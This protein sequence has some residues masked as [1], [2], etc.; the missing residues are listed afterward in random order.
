MCIQL[1]HVVSK[2]S[3]ALLSC[4]LPPEGSTWSDPQ[5][6]YNNLLVKMYN[7]VNF[8][9]VYVCGDFNS[10]IGSLADWICDSDLG[11]TQRVCLDDTI[12]TQGEMLIEFLRDSKCCVLNGRTPG[13]N[14]FTSISVKGK[15]G[16]GLYH[17]NT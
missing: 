3:L 17:Y 13:I 8:A 7:L 9:V 14:N 12:N 10:R 4:Y 6:M 15:S 11:I 2:Y 16:G 5:K 1:Q